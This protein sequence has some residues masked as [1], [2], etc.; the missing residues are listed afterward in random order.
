MVFL[1]ARK[2]KGTRKLEGVFV[3]LLIFNGKGLIINC[4]TKSI[5]KALLN[6]K[7][8]LNGTK[9]YSNGNPSIE[10]TFTARNDRYIFKNAYSRVDPSP[11]NL[12]LI[13][14]DLRMTK[15][16]KND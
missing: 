2:L 5:V 16:L 13:E 10:P 11:K 12:K 1:V 6:L 3:F 8:Y 4:L 7:T 9:E 15:M 14:K